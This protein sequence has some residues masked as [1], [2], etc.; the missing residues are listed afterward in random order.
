VGG[1][2]TAGGTTGHSHEGVSGKN[3]GENGKGDMDGGVR[4]ENSLAEKNKT[5]IYDLG[6]EGQLR[7]RHLWDIC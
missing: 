7:N 6:G 3:N 1:V 5:Q 2:L 4:R